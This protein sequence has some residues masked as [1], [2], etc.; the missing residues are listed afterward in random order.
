M[1]EIDKDKINEAPELIAEYQNILE[2]ISKQKDGSLGSVFIT[3]NTEEVKRNKFLTGAIISWFVAI[4]C[5]FIKMN[6]K[7][8]KIIGLLFFV[9]LGMIFGGIAVGFIGDISNKR[10]KAIVRSNL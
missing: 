5:L 9:I 3:N 10:I 1:M 8:G 6:N 4:L 2:E 7:W